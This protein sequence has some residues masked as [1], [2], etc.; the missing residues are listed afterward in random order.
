MGPE[1]YLATINLRSLAQSSRPGVRVCAC[2]LRDR[3]A[4][5][6]TGTDIPVYRAIPD[7]DGVQFA[8][9]SR[10][11][12]IRPPLLPREYVGS[13]PFK[14]VPYFFSDIFN[15]SYELWGDTSDADEVAYRGGPHN[16]ELQCLVDEGR[17]SGR[18]FCHEPAG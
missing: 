9:S 3:V 7:A 13:V 15:L 2:G 17:Q 10:Y 11:V 18:R 12:R 5:D 8:N 14:H 4:V 16:Q 1:S 6:T